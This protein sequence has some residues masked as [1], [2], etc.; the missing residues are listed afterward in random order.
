MS[1]ENSDFTVR[2]LAEVALILSRFSRFTSV[3][4]V[5]PS[6]ASLQ[7]IWQT[8]R[9]VEGRWTSQLDDWTANGTFSVVELER[10][11][12]RVFVSE[13]IVRV[14][15]TL[16]ERCLPQSDGGETIRFARHVV[17]GFSRVRNGILSRLLSIPETEASRVLA[18]DQVRRRCDRWTDVLL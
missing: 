17:D 11:A 14:W 18:V 3:R 13:M 5:A 7:N 12:P 6:V 15:G 16:V 4:P 9:Q 8:S 1:S 10:L 2:S